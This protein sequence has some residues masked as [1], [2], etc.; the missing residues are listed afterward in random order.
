MPKIKG[1]EVGKSLVLFQEQQEAKD[2][3]VQELRRVVRS[4]EP[5]SW[6]GGRGGQIKGQVESL[7]R[8]VALSLNIKATGEFEGEE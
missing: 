3:Q 7:V 4:E 8:T 5:R 1:P 2:G 6:G